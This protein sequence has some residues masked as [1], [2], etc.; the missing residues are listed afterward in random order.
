MKIIMISMLLSISVILSALSGPAFAQ[1][2]DEEPEMAL[3]PKGEGREE[4]FYLCSACHSIRTVVQQRLS[5][6]RWDQILDYM[7]AEQ[8]MP[9]LEDEERKLI[10][11]YLAANVSPIK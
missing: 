2:E 7:V 11:E 10:L 9:E 3:L 6:N 4:V 5:R 8:G 1:G